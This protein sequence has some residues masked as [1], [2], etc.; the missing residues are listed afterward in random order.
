MKITKTK[1]GKY[2]TRVEVVGSDG[3]RK[4]KSITADN[5]QDVRRIAA[6]YEITRE[7][8][9]PT[10]AKALDN[11]LEAKKAVLSPYTVKGYE[12]I[13]QKVKDANL[14]NLSADMSRPDAQKLVTEFSKLSQKTIK[15]RMGLISAAVRFAGYNMPPVTYPQKKKVELHVPTENEIRK[16]MKTAEGTELEIPV[17]LG[18]LGLRRGEICALEVFDLKKNTLHIHA[19]AVDIGGKVTIKAPKTY[20][21][22]R[23]IQIPEK[24]AR[25]IKKQGYVTKLTPEQLSYHSSVS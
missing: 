4:W 8:D 20:D 10:L 18:V 1:S 14:G 19:A 7:A 23:Y 13:I 24:L 2:H 12:N 22:D 25:K 3:K 21:S 11:Y 16:I 17:A 6:R 15:N 9:A 5:K